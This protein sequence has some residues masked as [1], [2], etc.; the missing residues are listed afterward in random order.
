M[1]WVWGSPVYVRLSPSVITALPMF[2]LPML[3]FF[4]TEPVKL[5]FPAVMV[6]V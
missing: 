2:S 4:S 3:N 6:R 5:L 1:V